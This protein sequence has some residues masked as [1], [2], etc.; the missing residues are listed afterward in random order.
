MS[1]GA[2]KEKSKETAPGKLSFSGAP[3]PERI[4]KFIRKHHVMTIATVLPGETPWC[5]N[6]FYSYM[7]EENLFVFTSEEK[8]RHA[9]EMS[10][11]GDAGASIVL[12]TKNVG[13]V[14]GLQ[15]QGRVSRPAGEEMKKAKASYLKR[16]PYA[17]VVELT[18]WTMEPSNM[19]LTD[20]RLGFGKKLY[21]QKY[22]SG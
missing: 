11:T 1:G 5:A 18:L 2:E 6:V 7:P 19:K 10:E 4:V 9:S 14:Q 12:E 21:W 8:T 13:L 3:V 20:N 16:F 22:G 15:L 17:S